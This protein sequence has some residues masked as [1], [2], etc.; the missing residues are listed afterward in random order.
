MKL[1]LPDW[2]EQEG[3]YQLKLGDFLDE[4]TVKGIEILGKNEN[5]QEYFDT[6]ITTR[7]L[8]DSIVGIGNAQIKLYKVAARRAGGDNRQLAD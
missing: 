2:T 4:L 6:R 1:Q 3:M 8:Y 7:N 5:P